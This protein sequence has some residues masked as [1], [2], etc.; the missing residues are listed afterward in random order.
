MILF[1]L[2]IGEMIHN[3]WTSFLENTIYR[4]FYYLEI[5]VCKIVGMMES[6]MMVFTGESKVRYTVGDKTSQMTLIRVFFQ[7]ENVRGIYGA[8]GIIGIAFAFVFAIVSVIRKVL[9]LRDKQQGVTI[10]AILGNL[11]KSIL[12]IASMQAIMLVALTTTDTLIKSVHLAVTNS[13]NWAKGNNEI[14][15]TDEQYAA[16]GRIFNTIGNY[17]LNPSYRTRYNLNACYNDIR[18]DLDFLGKQGVF[19]FSYVSYKNDD[20]EAGEIEPTWQSMV[21]QLARAYDYNKETPLDSYNDGLTNAMLNCMDIMKANPNIRVLK[22]Y[23]RENV[24]KTNSVPMDRILFLV[25]TMG[26]FTGDAAARVDIYNEEPS[27][28]DVVREPFYYGSSDIYNYSKVR[29]AFDPSPGKTNYVLVY[30]TGISLLSEMLVIIVT[31]SVRIFSLLTLYLASPLVI[32]ALPLDDGGKLKQWTTAFLVQLLGVVGMVLAMRLY[33]MFLP[34][35]WSPALEV[36]SNI[37]LTIIIKCIITYGGLTAVSRVNGILTGILA[38]NAGWQAISAGDMRGN[39]EGSAAGRF[40]G[41]MSASNIGSAVAGATVGKAWDKAS[42]AAYR[43]TVGK[44]YSKI[45]GKDID[46]GEKTAAQKT[47]DARKNAR[48]Q[49]DMKDN[50]KHAKETGKTLD[51]KKAGKKD[52]RQMQHALRHMQNDGMNKK[53]AMKAAKMDMKQDKRDAAHRAKNKE[54][55]LRN[56]PPGRRNSNSGNPA[57]GPGPGPAPTPGPAPVNNEANHQPLP[58]NQNDQVD[59][60]DDE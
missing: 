50:I 24:S 49:Q 55:A 8:I 43:G 22:Y 19:N 59:I 46:S 31:C 52:I 11:L 15:F 20:K 39:V 44:V 37:L 32:A 27:F 16:M 58:A 51:G 25:G 33:L 36:S 42:H 26:N 28:N 53:D 41:S 10:G 13:G 5:F 30:A 45:T 18:G 6:V 2:D 38:D 29:E 7:H 14:T 35:I 21:E 47:K 57:P 34:I 4:L 60:D 12:L 56:P 17:S 3:W 23:K 48:D 9:D 40:L 54:G 1:S